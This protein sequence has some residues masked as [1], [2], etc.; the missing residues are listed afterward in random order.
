ME[1]ILRWTFHPCGENSK[2]PENKI[3][4]ILEAMILV[5]ETTKKNIILSEDM[6]LDGLHQEENLI[7]GIKIISLVTVSHATGLDTRP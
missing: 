5:K 3:E 2:L 1:R 6:N 4:K 7:L